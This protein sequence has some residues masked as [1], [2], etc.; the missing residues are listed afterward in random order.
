MKIESKR[1]RVFQMHQTARLHAL[2]GL[3]LATLWQRA[4]GYFVDVFLAVALWV[5]LELSWRRYVLHENRIDLKWDFHEY[6]NILV[7]LLYWASFNFFGN[8]RTPGKFVTGTRA[9]SLTSERLGVWQ[10]I[11]RTL[12]YGAAILEGGLGFLQVFWDKNRMCAQDL[13]AETVVLD[14]RKR[15]ERRVEATATRVAQ[16]QP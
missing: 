11:E 13:L 3:P 7:M 6:G 14:V 15:S 1:G 10:S 16:P 5:P 8:G 12:G 4:F 9:V 2:E